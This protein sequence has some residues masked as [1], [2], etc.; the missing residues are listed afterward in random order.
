MDDSNERF[1]A[2]QQT[3]AVAALGSAN[4]KDRRPPIDSA[5]LMPSDIGVEIGPRKM[6]NHRSLTVTLPDGRTYV[7]PE[8]VGIYEEGWHL[9][10]LVREVER[11]FGFPLD[12]LIGLRSI[13]LT[14][15]KLARRE[16]ERRQKQ[17]AEAPIFPAMTAAQLDQAELDRTPLVE[18]VLYRGEPAIAAGAPKT[19]KTTIVGAELGLSLATATPFLGRFRVPHAVRVG[20]TT[21]ASQRYSTSSGLV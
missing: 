10:L 1:G 9:Q 6:N 15:M 5:S 20:L 12:S 2:S 21:R 7:N 19:L 16:E 11:H 18:G 14:R 3:A 17:T 4:G 13:I 8:P